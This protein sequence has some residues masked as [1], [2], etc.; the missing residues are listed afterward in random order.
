MA[1]PQNGELSKLSR[2][3]YKANTLQLILVGSQSPFRGFA[4]PSPSQFRL[5][6]KLSLQ[7]KCPNN[8]IEK[9][10]LCL[11]LSDTLK[12]D[13]W[14]AISSNDLERSVLQPWSKFCDFVLQIDSD[15]LARI[16]IGIEISGRCCKTIYLEVKISTKKFKSQNCSKTGKIS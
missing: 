9:R 5:L 16:L 8:F 15:K 1:S 10:S 7:R 3:K 13:L 6:A 12:E 11:K 4:I 2:Q 14:V